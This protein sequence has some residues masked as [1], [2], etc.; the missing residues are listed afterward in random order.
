MFDD[1][2]H[3]D[4]REVGERMRS[5]FDRVIEVERQ[6]AAVMAR[7]SAVLRDRLLDAEDS[8]DTA[9]VHVADGSV[10]RGTVTATA[11]DHVE[12]RPSG[13]AAVHLV[14]LDAVVWVRLE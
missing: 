12:L 3:P 11:V 2:D 13:E 10:H 9:T 8:G 5:R 6:A 4:L 7:R 14:P 1:I